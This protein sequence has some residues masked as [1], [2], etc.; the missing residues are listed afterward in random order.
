MQPMTRILVALGFVL[1]AGCASIGPSKMPNI[2]QDIHASTPEGMTRVIFF[3]PVSEWGK[4][5]NLN[6]GVKI[7]IDG[8]A[9]PY[10][11]H[12]HYFQVFLSS[13]T[14][15]VKLEHVDPFAFSDTYEIEVG[16]SDLFVKVFRKWAGNELLIMDQLPADFEREFQSAKSYP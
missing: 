8:N 7:E 6:I 4:R 10:I 12:S 9:G 2:N 15:V 16:R 1:L 11:Q 5:L 14:H 3:N 13:G